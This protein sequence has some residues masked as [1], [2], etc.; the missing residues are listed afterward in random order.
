MQTIIKTATKNLYVCVFLFIVLAGVSLFIFVWL[1][2]VTLLDRDWVAAPTIHCW[3]RWC[4]SIHICSMLQHDGLCMLLLVVFFTFRSLSSSPSSSLLFLLLPMVYLYISISDG[5]RKTSWITLTFKWNVRSS[6]PL[7]FY[8]CYDY[9]FRVRS[10]DFLF[11]FSWYFIFFLKN[12][13]FLL[14]CHKIVLFH[15]KKKI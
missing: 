14:C 1:F 6:I 4:L 10:L 3:Y 5:T 8:S 15:A 7:F 9:F 2:L 12:D 11:F 13:S